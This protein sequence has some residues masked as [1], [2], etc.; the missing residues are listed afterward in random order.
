MNGAQTPPQAAYN[1]R[2]LLAELAADRERVGRAAEAAP[3]LLPQ[4][5]PGVRFTR[6]LLATLGWPCPL[7]E[8]L[9][10]FVQALVVFG[11]QAVPA[12][13]SPPTPGDL[14]VLVDGERVPVELGLVGAKAQDEG[15]FTAI[16]AD[17]KRTR[18]RPAEVEFWLRVPC[19]G[20]DK[21]A[22]ATAVPVARP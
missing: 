21:K 4:A 14:Y 16:G 22:A 2:Q 10:E 12:A 3:L 13:L 7:P 9:R 20:C 8:G 11:W 5:D 15:Y 17:A 19:A 6:C 1:P 18:R